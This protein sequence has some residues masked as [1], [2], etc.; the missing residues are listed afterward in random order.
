MQY[1]FEA[2]EECKSDKLFTLDNSIFD[3]GSLST[4][5]DESSDKMPEIVINLKSLPDVSTIISDM[6]NYGPHNHVYKEIYG[7]GNDSEA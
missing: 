4:R 3:N 5:S 1:T 2:K 7:T 6:V